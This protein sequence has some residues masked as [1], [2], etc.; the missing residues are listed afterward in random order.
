MPRACA[1]LPTCLRKREDSENAPP[2]PRPLLQRPPAERARAARRQREDGE[3]KKKSTKRATKDTNTPEQGQA[4]GADGTWREP[5]GTARGQG[6][7]P[8]GRKL[9]GRDQRGGAG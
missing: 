4:A 1:V 8:W 2:P 3:K 7:R 9:G 5:G 6:Q